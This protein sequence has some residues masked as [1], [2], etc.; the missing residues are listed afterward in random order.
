MQEWGLL[1]QCGQADDHLLDANG[2]IV[3]FMLVELL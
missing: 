2:V 1:I 3:A